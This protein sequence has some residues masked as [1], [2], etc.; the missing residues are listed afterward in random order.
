FES[1]SGSSLPVVELSRREP[2]HTSPSHHRPLRTMES[3]VSQAPSRTVVVLAAHV[4]AA[5]GAA[6]ATRTI[7]VVGHKADQVRAHLAEIAPD[8]NAVLQAEQ[9]GT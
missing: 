5:A 2:L 9:N 8:A 4:L 3:R 6:E 7:V 1:S